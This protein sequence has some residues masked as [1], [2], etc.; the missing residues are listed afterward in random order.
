[1]AAEARTRHKEAAA[2]GLAAASQLV[3]LQDVIRLSTAELVAQVAGDALAAP[4]KD[5][6]TRPA[7]SVQQLLERFERW[8]AAG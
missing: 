7:A 8:G 3:E 2:K 5:S 1:M 6:A 4:S